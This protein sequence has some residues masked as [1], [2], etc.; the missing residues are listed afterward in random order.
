[1]FM[2]LPFVFTF[3]LAQFAAGLV[4]YWSCSS[5]ERTQSWV[6]GP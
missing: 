5:R 1:M 4:I 3:M 6:C 2:L